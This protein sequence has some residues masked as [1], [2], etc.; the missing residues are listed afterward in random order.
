[1]FKS[2]A[3]KC[4]QAAYW[5]ER[6]VDAIDINLARV[7]LGNKDVSIVVGTIFVRIEADHPRRPDVVLMVKEQHNSTPVAFITCCNYLR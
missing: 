5:I 2:E 3:P 7:H 4:E 1:M 6:T